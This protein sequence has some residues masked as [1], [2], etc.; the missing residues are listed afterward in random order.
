MHVGWIKSYNDSI[1]IGKNDDDVSLLS[2]ASAINIGGDVIG[3][4]RNIELTEE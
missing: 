2:N 1:H 4:R 3:T